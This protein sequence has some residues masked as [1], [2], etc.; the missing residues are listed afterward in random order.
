MLSEFRLEIKKGLTVK[1]YLN[2]RIERRNLL[3]LGLFRKSKKEGDEKADM[4]PSE[5]K[6]AFDKTYLKA[7]PLRDLSDLEAIKNEVKNGNVLI[8]RITPLASKS[9]EDVKHAV[10]ELYEF[11]ESV[12][13]DIARLGEERVVICPQNIRIWREKKRVSK[14]PLPT[15]A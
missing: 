1:S 2:S 5:D 9:I 3:T 10:N 11:A 13:G 8:L 14:E 4:S 7:M 15:A 6:E 12:G